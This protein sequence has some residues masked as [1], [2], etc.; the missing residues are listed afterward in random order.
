MTGFYIT[1]N[2]NDLQEVLDP[3]GQVSAGVSKQ[4]LNSKGTLRL[5]GRDIF[6]TQVMAGLTHFESVIE[7]FSLKRDSRVVTLSFTYRFGKV[8]KQPKRSGGGATDEINRV[9]TVN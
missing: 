9:G 3:T 4:I 1:R 2:Q 8:I 5:S 7:Y 6:Y